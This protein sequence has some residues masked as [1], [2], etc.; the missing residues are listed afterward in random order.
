M[1]LIFIYLTFRGST[2]VMT[3]ASM[4]GLGLLA[5]SSMSDCHCR[6]SPTNFCS[7]SSKSVWTRCSKLDGAE[8]WIRDFF[9][10]VNMLAAEAAAAQHQTFREEAG[11]TGEKKNGKWKHKLQVRTWIYKVWLQLNKN[12]FNDENTSGV[13]LQ[14]FLWNTILF[15]NS[16]LSQLCFFCQWVSKGDTPSSQ[17]EAC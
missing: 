8:I 5:V 9:F 6:G 14:T 10:L 16:L 7:C 17:T 4:K 12:P 2:V 11:K 1:K 15:K 3:F 13:E